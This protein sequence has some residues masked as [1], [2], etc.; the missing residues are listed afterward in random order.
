[1]LTKTVVTEMRQ[2]CSK[3]DHKYTLLQSLRYFVTGFELEMFKTT[4]Q[5]ICNKYHYVCKLFAEHLSI[6]LVKV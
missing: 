3:S 2:K 1:M 5:K 4:T 6:F